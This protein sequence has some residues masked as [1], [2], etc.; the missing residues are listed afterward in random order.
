MVSV[1]TQE[2]EAKVTS[3]E[4]SVGQDSLGI[5][6]LRS[7]LSFEDF[8]LGYY[9]ESPNYWE[10]PDPDYTP[11][12]V[13]LDFAAIAPV[14]PTTPGKKEPACTCKR[15]FYDASS[16]FGDLRELFPVGSQAN[17]AATFPIVALTPEWID[18]L[19]ALD[20]DQK[21]RTNPE[22]GEIEIRSN[23]L[24]TL[25]ELREQGVV[26]EPKAAI[27]TR[28]G[29]VQ[30]FRILRICRDEL[31]G[32]W[33]I[34]STDL[35]VV[36]EQLKTAGIRR[37]G[38]LYPGVELRVATCYSLIF[39]KVAADP[40]SFGDGQYRWIGEMPTRIDD[41]PLLEEPIRQRVLQFFRGKLSDP[42]PERKKTRK[43][44]KTSVERKEREVAPGHIKIT[45]DTLDPMI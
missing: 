25:E 27:R 43:S 20:A 13:A 18:L 21:V 7:L 10:P 3:K 14:F 16:D 4:I 9:G 45:R 2:I 29:G 17:V 30:F 15:G 5:S 36:K 26:L 34:K 32:L 22:T 19:C 1:G 41:I 11:F 35:Q 39:G 24:G 33:D 23:G 38:A 40:G 44:S 6:T 42:K 8:W 37:I 31:P 12:D 28:N